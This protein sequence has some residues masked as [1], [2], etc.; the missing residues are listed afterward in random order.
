MIECEDCKDWFHTCCVGVDENRL[1]EK[2]ICP[3]CQGIFFFFHFYLLKK[4]KN[5]TKLSMK[6][7][8]NLTM[9]F[10]GQQRQNKIIQIGVLFKILQS[11]FLGSIHLFILKNYAEQ[12]CGLIAKPQ[13]PS[14]LQSLLSIDV[15]YVDFL[16]LS[17]ILFFFL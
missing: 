2:Y 5:N 14:T 13:E 9:L 10:D 16:F 12:I 15:D 11:I 1:P 17:S 6:E 4:K 8:L 3:K 7:F